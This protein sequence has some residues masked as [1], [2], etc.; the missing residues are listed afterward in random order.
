MAAIELDR[1]QVEA[2]REFKG[3]AGMGHQAEVAPGVGVEGVESHAGAHGLVS[4]IQLLELAQGDA[5]VVPHQGAVGLERQA[6][7]VGR[8][9]LGMA[10]DVVVEVAEVV[11]GVGSIGIEPECC[12][13]GVLR[14]PQVLGQPPGAHAGDHP[15]IGIGLEVVLVAAVQ[16]IGFLIALQLPEGHAGG[17]GP[18]G[19][20]L[21][22]LQ[23]A[24]RLLQRLV[25]IQLAL[26]QGMETG[27]WAQAM[28]SIGPRV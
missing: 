27:I 22:L 7:L 13:E 12:L 5:E 15:G 25:G 9:R 11:V 23:L 6:G 20:G 28:A 2:F 18:E 16:L 1:V 14:I 10:V 8:Y 24:L 3:L 26:G 4:P 21:G 17:Q 19:I